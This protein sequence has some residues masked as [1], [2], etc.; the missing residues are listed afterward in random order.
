MRWHADVYAKVPLPPLTRPFLGRLFDDQEV[1][2][3]GEI[4]LPRK[5]TQPWLPRRKSSVRVAKT[6][7]SVRRRRRLRTL[8]TRKGGRGPRPST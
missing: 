7:R 2:T 5:A 3:V 1:E 6:H 8:G 4:V